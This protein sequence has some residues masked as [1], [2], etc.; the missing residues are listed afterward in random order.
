MTGVIRIKAGFGAGFALLLGICYASIQQTRQWEDG[1]RAVARSNQIIERL[2]ELSLQTTDADAAARTYIVNSGAAD[3]ARCR[4]S[5]AQ[6]MATERNLEALVAGNTAQKQKMQTVQWLVDRQAEAVLG[7]LPPPNA[8]DA[9]AA[10]GPGDVRRA[11]VALDTAG[12]GASLRSAVV[13]M[14]ADEGGA[15]KERTIRQERTLAMSRV[16]FF[17]ASTVSF[18][19]IVI[20]G[21]RI[22]SEQK[23]RNAR[24]NSDSREEQYRRVVELAGDIICRT[25]EHGRFTL[26]NQAALTLLHFSQDEVVGRSWLKFVRQDKRTAAR[27]FY[28]RQI[29]RR[30]SSS[31]YELPLIDGHGGERWM[32]LHVQLVMENNRIAGLQAIGRDVTDRRRMDAELRRSRTFAEKVAATTPG[33][34]CV[35]DLVERRNIYSNREMTSV[36]GYKPREMPNLTTLQQEFYHP[37]DQ[38][39]IE[40][41]RE[42]L[43]QAP[44]GEI[45]RLEY[46]VRHAGGHWVWL[47]AVE[48]AFERGPDGLVKQVVGISQDITARKEAHDRLAWHANYDVLTGLRNRQHF[49]SGLHSV[50]RRASIDHYGTSLCLFDVDHF[51]AINDQF[52]HAAGDEVLEAVGNI[53]RAELRATDL[54]GRLG[55]DEFCF[56]LPRTGC[57]ECAR[58]ADRIRDRLSTLAFGLGSGGPFT[59]TATFGVA[60]SDPDVNAK[61]LMEAADRALY[62]AKSEGRNRV[63]VA[64]A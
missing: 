38:P 35:Y 57:E 53:V 27:R 15:L 50:L 37:D 34:L 20:V 33:I 49:W 64:A 42:A 14:Q 26:C 51:K 62:Q 32:A 19:L 5:L 30:R 45:R 63:T 24:Q 3:L 16:L 47:S 36:L 55:G 11:L 6:A 54:A 2:A 58:V 41:H 28:N 48:T 31:V 25:D 29:G 12:L 8:P 46:R 21:V 13:G 59:V 9:V 22:R 39:V 1:A 40:Q 23:R 43:R 60:E 17:A 61:E 56:A 18:I 10:A 4:R 52:G 44:D 7:S